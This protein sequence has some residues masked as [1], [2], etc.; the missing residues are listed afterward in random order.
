MSRPRRKR[1]PALRR[2]LPVLAAARGT[3]RRCAFAACAAAAGAS[4]TAAAQEASSSGGDARPMTVEIGAGAEYDSNITVLEL[5]TISNRSDVAALVDFS[6]AYAARPSERLS[7]DVG[8]HFSDRLHEDFDQYDV[9]I[10]RGS[11]ELGF[12]FDAFD[13]GATFQYADASLAG[14]GFLVLKQTSPYVSRLFGERLFQRFAYVR[15]DKDFARNPG[16]D[17]DAHALSSDTYVFVDGLTTYLSFG[18]R[19]DTE[20]AV[21]PQFDYE[22]HRLKAQLSKRIPVAGRE[23]RLRAALRVQMR[24]YDYPTPSIGEPR[25]EDRWR[26]EA[27]A[28]LPITDSLTGSFGYTRSDNRSNLPVL[29]FAENVVS[30]GLRAS[31]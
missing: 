11:A 28:E 13:A 24:R 26:L 5:D 10:H 27:S 16:R 15:T 18:Y 12:D 14:D 23:L 6:A 19:Y 29:D 20:D 30:A 22:G 25:R 1:E 17:T 3:A 21:E 2:R 8:Y 4:W 9:R 31:F 7:V